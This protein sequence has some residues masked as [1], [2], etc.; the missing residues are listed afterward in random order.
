[1]S[2][3]VCMYVCVM[4]ICGVFGVCVVYMMYVCLCVVCLHVC[5]CDVCVW[6]VSMYVVYVICVCLCVVYLRVC[7]YDVCPC[8]CAHMH[9]NSLPNIFPRLESWPSAHSC[10]E[11]QTCPGLHPQQGTDCI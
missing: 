6:C 2:L 11:E 5:V 10:V 7:V 1:M 8:M 9:M 3:R 4:C